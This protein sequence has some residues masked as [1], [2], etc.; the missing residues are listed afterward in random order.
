MTRSSRMALYLVLGAASA[1][2]STAG[3]A[4]ATAD[5]MRKQL[6]TAAHLIEDS[7]AAKRVESSGNADAQALREQ[8]RVLFHQAKHA[9]DSGRPDDAQKLL[10]DA[11]KTMLKAVQ[12][13]GAGSERAEKAK[14]DY[15]MRAQSVRALL[16]AQGRV[17][18]EKHAGQ[19]EDRLHQQVEG[20][21]SEAD[22][23]YRKD[24]YVGGKAKL[25]LAYEQLKVSIERMRD[26]DVLE[27]K[28]V[29]DTIQDQ[30]NYYRDKTASQLEAIDMAAGSVAGTSKEK[31]IRTFSEKMHAARSEAGA[32]AE[33]GDYEAAVKV[34][35]PMFKSAPYQLMSLLR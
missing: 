33:R 32:L 27:H 6:E 26:G 4:Q 21:L 14:R 23:L 18:G 22:A 29:F 2:W 30:Y 12:T 20:L 24:D 17:A 19:Q 15:D 10:A 7:S 28:V 34:L 13:A 3:G 8:A 5:A 25:D 16:Q 1:A 35:E 31:M 11:K 9:L